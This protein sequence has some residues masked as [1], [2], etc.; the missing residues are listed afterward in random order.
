M[1]MFFIVRA[2][3]HAPPPTASF[4]KGKDP[5]FSATGGGRFYTG[6]SRQF[7]FSSG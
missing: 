6:L 3:Y 5:A 1:F 4:P 2:V 7:G